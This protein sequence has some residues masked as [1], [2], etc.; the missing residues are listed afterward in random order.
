MRPLY[1]LGGIKNKGKYAFN[2]ISN[3]PSVV[4]GLSIGKNKNKRVENFPAGE[5]ENLPIPTE[6]ESIKDSICCDK[7]KSNLNFSSLQIPV[8]GLNKHSIPEEEKMQDVLGHFFIV[9]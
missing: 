8:K 7:D 6:G 5:S 2:L 9:H 1:F 4:K 3:P